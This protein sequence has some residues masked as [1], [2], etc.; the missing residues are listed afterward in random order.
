MGLVQSPDMPTLTRWLTAS[1]PDHE[2][3]DRFP[4]SP[5]IWILTGIRAKFRPRRDA[6]QPLRARVKA[7]TRQ[8]GNHCLHTWWMRH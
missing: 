2:D 5:R 6:L 8:T 3:G 4:L 1:Y 7:V